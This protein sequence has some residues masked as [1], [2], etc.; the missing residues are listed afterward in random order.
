MPPP[1]PASLPQQALSVCLL[2]LPPEPMQTWNPAAAFLT[3]FFA[4]LFNVW[5]RKDGLPTISGPF[6]NGFIC[7]RVGV[8]IGVG[9]GGS[10][11][12]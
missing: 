8:G 9:D 10:A 11:L 4:S 12:Y 1:A 2:F 3:G 6:K 5:Y 7:N